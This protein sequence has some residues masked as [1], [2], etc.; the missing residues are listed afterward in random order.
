LNI[1]STTMV[2]IIVANLIS[3]KGHSDLLQAVSKIQ[4]KM[5]ED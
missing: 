4:D 1:P 5:P 3:Y 2:M